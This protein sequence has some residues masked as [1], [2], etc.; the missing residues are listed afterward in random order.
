MSTRKTSLSLALVGLFAFACGPDGDPEPLTQPQ[1]P[2]ASA[3]G[4]YELS[5]EPEAGG[6]QWPNWALGPQTIKAYVKPGPDPLPDDPVVV[7][8]LPADPPYTMSV[9]QAPLAGDEKRAPAPKL[10]PL[11]SEG[12]HWA[13]GPLE[14][15]AP[16][17]WVFA[18]EIGNGEGV[19][20]TVELR[21]EVE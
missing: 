14:L 8:K 4:Y 11:D 19:L 1:V 3:N 7:G 13:L 17:Y 6:K 16:G 9:V 10:T 15:T 21:F 18:V 2:V 12:K 5:V 20:D